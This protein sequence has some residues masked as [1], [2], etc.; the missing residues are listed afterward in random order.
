M[1]TKVLQTSQ[2]D[3]SYIL[4]PDKNNQR[5]DGLESA[6]VRVCVCACVN[7]SMG[8][9]AQIFCDVMFDDTFTYRLGVTTALVRGL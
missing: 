2:C 9:T 5:T 1:N 3:F 7:V 8:K 4:I 6:C